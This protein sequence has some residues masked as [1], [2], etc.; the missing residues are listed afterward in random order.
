MRVSQ[1]L[2]NA[3]RLSDLRVYE[4]AHRAGLH[5]SMVSKLIHGAEIPKPRDK[6]VI[7]I[8]RVVGLPESACFDPAKHEEE[9]HD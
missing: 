7:A 2:R 1:K 4:I 6:R 5:P 8:G 3:V 9:R